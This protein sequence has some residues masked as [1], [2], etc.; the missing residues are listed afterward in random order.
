MSS[1]LLS[2]SSFVFISGDKKMFPCLNII[3][4]KV[5]VLLSSELII[6]T[7]RILKYLSCNFGNFQ[8]SSSL[9]NLKIKGKGFVE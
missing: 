7:A 6:L 2:R 4:A 5:I 8:S 9:R 3:A 1:F